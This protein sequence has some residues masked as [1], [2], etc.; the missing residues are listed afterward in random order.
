VAE[1]AV[2]AAGRPKDILTPG[3]DPRVDAFLGR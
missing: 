3:R 1:G 2:L